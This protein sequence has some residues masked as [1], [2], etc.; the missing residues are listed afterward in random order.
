MKPKKQEEKL[1]NWETIKE[2]DLDEIRAEAKKQAL[3]KHRWVQKGIWLE[4]KSCKFRHGFYVGI[5]KVLV[6]VDEEG[7]PI[8]KDKKEVFK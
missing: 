7:N 1:E 8:L 5:N 3:L 6:G 4:C 2:F